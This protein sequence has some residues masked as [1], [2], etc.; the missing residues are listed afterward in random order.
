[1]VDGTL[2][3]NPGA[4]VTPILLIGDFHTWVTV[5]LFM[6]FVFLSAVTVMNMLIGVI[7]EVVSGATVNEKDECAIKALKEWV[8]V[9]LNKFDVDGNHMISQSELQQAL[10]DTHAQQVFRDL[11]IDMQYMSYVQEM[12]FEDSDTEVHIH[13]IMELLLSSRRDLPTTFRHL[14]EQQEFTRWCLHTALEDWEDRMLMHLKNMLTVG[15]ENGSVSKDEFM[16]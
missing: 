8:L 10:A 12:L 9:E 14:A 5:T 4:R 7:C 3:D 6:V 16:L 15:M 2:L 1:V 11:G 13:K